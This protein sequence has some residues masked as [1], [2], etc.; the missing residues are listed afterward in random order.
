MKPESLHHHYPVAFVFSVVSGRAWAQPP[1]GAVPKAAP[2][3][4]VR[5]SAH[6]DTNARVGVTSTGDTDLP[7][8]QKSLT[9]SSYYGAFVDH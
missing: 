8:R 9:T 4:M 5:G 1:R 3:L 7:H 6:C 2:V